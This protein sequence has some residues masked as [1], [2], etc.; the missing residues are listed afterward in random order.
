MR[1]IISTMFLCLWI[2]C[3]AHAQLPVTEGL[4]VHLRAD[5]LIDLE[6]GDPVTVW[7][8][9]ARGDPVDGTVGDVGSGNPEYKA[10]VMFGRPVVRFN[11]A[12]ALSSAQFS[13]PDPDAGATC[14]MVC[15][16]DKTGVLHERLGHF[17]A[18]DAVGGVSISMD[19][20]TQQ[21]TA[22]G[23]GFRLNNGWSLAGN[24]NPM[25]TGF[26]VGVWQ[27]SQGTLQSDLIY[28]LDGIR[29]TLTQNNPNNMV[30]FTKT[31]NVVAVGNG[32]SPGG[33]FYANDYVTADLAVF[34]I[35]NRVLSAAEV[36]TLTEYLHTEY[37]LNRQAM[38]PNPASGSMV[39]NRLITLG[40]TTGDEAVSHRVYLDTNEEDVVNAEESTLVA[41]TNQSSVLIGVIG[42]PL[43][44]GLTPG[45]KYYWRVDEISEDG[46]VTPGL[47]WSFSVPPVT[48]SAP[49]P[50]NGA[51]FVL[52]DQTL[53]WSPGLG[54]LAHTVYFGTNADVVAESTE[55]LTQVAMSYTPQAL[56]LDTTY[57]WRV[58]EFTLDG[59]I[60]GPVWS[61]TT[62][63]E[64]NVEDDSLLGW[65]NMD[66]VGTASIL[67]MSGHGNHGTIQGEV[68]WVNGVA[69]TALVMTEDDLITI[70][71]LNVTIDEL[72]M[73]GW[74]KTARVHG[75]TGIIFMRD[76][77]LTTGI[78]L[79]PNNQLGYH[80]LDVAESWQYESGLIAPVDEWAFIA[81]V[82]T[83]DMAKFYLDSVDTVRE[84]IRM[85]EPVTFSGELTLG[86]DTLGSARRYVG[87]LDDLRFYNRAL[88]VNELA[89]LISSGTRPLQESDPMVIENFDSY[90]AYGGDRGQWIWDVW[91]DGL[92]G[93]GTG[94]TL[95]NELEPIMSRSVVID[96]GQ[97]LPLGY[98]NTGTFVDLNGNKANLLLSE[99]S[100]SFSPIQDLTREGSTALT[101]W[102]QGNQT[103]TV[104]ATDSLYLAVKDTTGREAMAVVAP[105]SDLL[106]F[107][108][109]K[110][111]V[112]LND[113]VN[114]DLSQISGLII[115]IGQQ[116]SPQTGG[117]GTLLIDNII[118][119]I[120]ED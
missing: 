55:G 77:T 113:L 34:I 61:F 72:T 66:Q 18:W 97:A 48:A 111:T 30:T 73:T 81:M 102:I 62:I 99:I 50:S 8:D 42:Q 4:I 12:E 31:G 108:W 78:N 29:Q 13:I 92:G 91:S 2:M 101:L 20:C 33:T 86:S 23:S 38:D 45:S 59:T 79:M 69:D 74:I 9:S 56:E 107:Y 76:G 60:K 87:A 100:R 88:T 83:P 80:W 15:S 6:D 106:K 67:D 7:I 51:T 25:T 46:I 96:G 43:P 16:G 5:S 40:W 89:N 37:L 112:K 95:G 64:I 10:D 90:K 36:A 71:P 3:A 118:L 109:Q 115:G 110:K 98:D 85:H 53:A 24:P 35:Y 63:G 32:H 21:G 39:T 44:E 49:I 57:Y 116:A 17:G 22:Q 1:R 27:A 82:V 94:S 11:G 28:Y 14:V 114:V 120:E 41:T 47:V 117:R 103:N 104:E 68:E 93:N 105:A 58:D 84:L 70:P 119:S 52:T 75:R 54:A 65:W 26:H 19:V